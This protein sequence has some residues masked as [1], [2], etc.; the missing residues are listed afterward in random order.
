LFKTKDRQKLS[1]A[2]KKSR[3]LAPA[4]KPTY[5]VNTILFL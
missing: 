3:N 4:K 5:T 1:N 2:K